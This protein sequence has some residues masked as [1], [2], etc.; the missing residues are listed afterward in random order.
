MQECPAPLTVQVLA[1]GQVQ[2]VGDQCAGL[3]PRLGGRA[4]LGPRGY[5]LGRLSSPHLLFSK[6]HL[7]HSCG[8][9]NTSE[10]QLAGGRALA[11]RAV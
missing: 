9:N 8:Q 5:S 10:L 7:S 4:R 6:P 11:N 1:C 3:G 2:Y